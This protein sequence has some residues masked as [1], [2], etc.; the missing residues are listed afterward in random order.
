MTE[1]WII[2]NGEVVDTSTGMTFDSFTELLTVLNG[3]SR[4]LTELSEENKK[5]KSVNQE[6]RKELQ[7]DAQ[8]YKIFIEVIN[9]ADDLICSHLSKHYQRQW[10]NFCKTREIDV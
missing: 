5:L 10:K 2:E 8:Q 9:E 7:L 1:K 6:L 3:Q 4:H